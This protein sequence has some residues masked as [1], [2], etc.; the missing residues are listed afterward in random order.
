MG[1]CAV[2]GS[3]L[4]VIAWIE[5]ARKEE[6]V[7]TTCHSAEHRSMVWA[8]GKDCLCLAEPVC[9]VLFT[10]MGHSAK[11]VC[12]LRRKISATRVSFSAKG[13]R[14]EIVHAQLA[15]ALNLVVWFT[16]IGLNAE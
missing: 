3:L 1:H 5:F 2:F 16:A 10:A 6:K 15:S 11:R 14:E 7:S 9:G 4:W 13:H 12:A 8:R